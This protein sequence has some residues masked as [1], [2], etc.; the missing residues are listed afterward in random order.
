MSK[1]KRIFVLGSCSI[2]YRYN[3]LA[4]CANRKKDV[5]SQSESTASTQKAA[6]T[7]SSGK[8]LTFHNPLNRAGEEI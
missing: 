4:G 2:S 7:K 6:S 8:V 1:K 3:P 5:E